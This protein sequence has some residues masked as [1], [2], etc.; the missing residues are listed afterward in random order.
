VACLWNEI[1]ARSQRVQAA[2]LLVLADLNPLS[3]EMMGL[4]PTTPCLQSQIGRGRNLG[5]R[6]L[7]YQA[8]GAASQ[9]CG[10]MSLPPDAAGQQQP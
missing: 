3:V 6:A 1:G 4:E 2:A 10:S 5:K 8:W 9:S 7:R